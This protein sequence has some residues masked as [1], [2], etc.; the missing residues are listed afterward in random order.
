M[1]AREIRALQGKAY[2][3]VHLRRRAYFDAVHALVKAA[4][5][6]GVKALLPPEDE[7]P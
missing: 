5:S 7:E 2:E 4:Y 3:E 6:R 1:C